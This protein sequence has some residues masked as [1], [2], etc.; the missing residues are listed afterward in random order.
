[1]VER[2][3]APAIHYAD[4]AALSG[5]HCPDG[6]HLDVR[7]TRAFTMALAGIA[8]DTLVSSRTPGP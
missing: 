2:V 1:M 4:V 8:K 7:E 5:H 3:D 6:S